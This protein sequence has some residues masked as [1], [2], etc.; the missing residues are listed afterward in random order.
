[1]FFPG[2]AAEP[3]GH[4]GGDVGHGHV[5]LPNKVR[6]IQSQIYNFN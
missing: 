3:H 4:G 1:M 5:H 6:N 2:A